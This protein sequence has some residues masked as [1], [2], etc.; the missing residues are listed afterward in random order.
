MERPSLFVAIRICA[1]AEDDAWAGKPFEF[2]AAKVYNQSFAH[3]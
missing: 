2:A 3:S 1:S